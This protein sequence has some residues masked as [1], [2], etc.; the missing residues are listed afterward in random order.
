MQNMNLSDLEL[1]QLREQLGR[2][3]EPRGGRR[4]L[5]PLRTSADHRHG[6]HPGRCPGLSGHQ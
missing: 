4:Q 1:A 6:G 5:H 3:P 2:L